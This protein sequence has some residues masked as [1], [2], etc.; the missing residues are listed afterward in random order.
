MPDK[1]RI[2]T[3]FDGISSDYDRLNHLLSLGIDRSWRRRALR[4]IVDPRREQR[5]LDVACGTGDFSIAIARKMRPGSRVTG[6]DLSPGM[7]AVMQEK[8]RKSGLQDRID[9]LEGDC[10][11]LP[12]QAPCFDVVTIAFGIRNFEDRGAALREILRVLKPGG[13]LV[14]LEL[15]VPSNPLLRALYKLYFTRLLPRIGGAVS[16]DRR[17]YEYLPASVLGFPGPQQWT[18][19]MQECGYAEV[20]HRAFSLGICRM[21]TGTRPA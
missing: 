11:K 3:M 4:E 17:A 18:A 10:E 8:L 15:S 2:R 6:L 21:Y 7:L 16:G 14:I 13:K 20:R 12:W 19:F 1:K 9:T 5:I